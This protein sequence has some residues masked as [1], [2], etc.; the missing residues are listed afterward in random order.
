MGSSLKNNCWDYLNCNYGPNSE[1]PCPVVIDETSDGVNEGKN[2]GR[3]CWTVP[4]TLCFNKPMGR[5]SGKREICL[6]CDFFKLVK[7]EEGDSFYLFKLAQGVKGPHKLHDTIFQMEHLLSIHERLRS[8][9][10]LNI[11]LNEITNDARLIT[12]AQ[13][14]IVLLLKGDPPALY[15]EF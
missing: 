12:G 1:N 2:A 7:D 11:T 13:R 3:I 6:A 15:G 9:F 14:S 10:D 4:F 5:F 8:H